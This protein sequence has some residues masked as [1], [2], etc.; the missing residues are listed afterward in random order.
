MSSNQQ[1]TFNGGPALPSER[2]SVRDHFAGLAMN[3]LIPLPAF[4][5]AGAQAIAVT[6]YHIADAMLEAS[7]ASIPPMVYLMGVAPPAPK[8][9]EP[10][11]AEWDGQW[12]MDGHE[13]LF[14]I[15]W[16]ETKNP[17]ESER[18][19]RWN[20]ERERQRVLQWPRY[21]AEQLLAQKQPKP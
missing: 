4:D 20:E 11:V 19:S 2:T 13:K 16:D 8:W 14:A 17:A 9:F 5:A 3:A 12:L 6:A 7:Y 1:P 15:S 21:W 10:V 18:A